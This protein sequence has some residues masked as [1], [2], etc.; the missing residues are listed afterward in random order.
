VSTTYRTPLKATVLFAVLAEAI[1]AI[2]TKSQDVLFT[3][4]GAA[5]LLPAVIYAAT[6]LLFIV[7]RRSL[8]SNGKFDLGKWETPVVV[9]ASM[10]LLFE[11]ALFRD[12]SFKDAWVYVLFMTL[13]G[14]VYLVQL[15]ARRGRHGLVMPDMHNI[16]AAFESE[17]AKL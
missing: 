16:D 10:W 5:T 4:F 7:K 2:S 9:L 17:T 8:P 15:L 3:L 6:V 14:A 11:L 12:A 13:V 1:L